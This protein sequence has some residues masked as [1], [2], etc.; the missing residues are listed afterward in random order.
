MNLLA[1]NQALRYCRTRRRCL[2]RARYHP[3]SRKERRARS[4][5]GTTRIR[6]SGHC[7]RG[8]PLSRLLCDAP[9]LV[10]CI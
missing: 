2:D 7:M 4:R 3:K 1:T 6:E 10:L 8:R 9:V 5:T